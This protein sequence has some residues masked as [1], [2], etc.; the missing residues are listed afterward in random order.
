MLPT[1]QD[2]GKAYRR[3][4]DQHPSDQ[5]AN[6]A[7]GHGLPLLRRGLD[8]L[9][10]IVP[11]IVDQRAH[12]NALHPFRR[13]GPKQRLDLLQ[14]SGR[15]QPAAVVLRGNDDRHPVV[16]GAEHLVCRIR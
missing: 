12:G 10:R 8:A 16:D 15:V 6:E 9:R 3:D 1:D 7:L 13:K 11:R 5:L 14:R 4:N 2:N